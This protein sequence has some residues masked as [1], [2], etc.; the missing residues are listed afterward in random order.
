VTSENDVWDKKNLETAIDMA[1][2]AYEN[3]KY[4]L[5]P[6]QKLLRYW[7]TE[8]TLVAVFG[9]SGTG[10]TT[11]G[12]FVTGQSQPFG[13]PLNY[14][15]SHNSESYSVNNSTCHLIAAPGQ[16][17]SRRTSWNKL[18]SDII[19]G[20]VIG[21][22]NVVCYGYHSLRT[23]PPFASSTSF[24]EEYFLE[25][26][27][28]EIKIIQELTPYL[29]ASPGKIRMLTLINKQDLW[30]NNQQTVEKYYQEGDYQKCLDEILVVKGQQNFMHEYVPVSFVI[31]NFQVDSKIILQNCAGYDQQLQGEQLSRFLEKIQN[32][33]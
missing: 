19:S 23:V 4:F 16:F 29:K 2:A 33:V 17:E 20:Q 9:P 30:W 31:A 27:Q 6:L 22:I 28:Q 21:V 18:F 7:K 1:K 13:K 8:K 26:R 12:H 32:L 11:L 25:R 5:I 3:R 24:W 10:K 14:K 15:E